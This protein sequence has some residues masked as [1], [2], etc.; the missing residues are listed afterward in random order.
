M[1]LAMMDEYAK[2]NDHFEA[3][4]VI[5]EDVNKNISD[6][7]GTYLINPS[8]SVY[9]G[10]DHERLFVLYFKAL[11]F[12]KL[13]DYESALVECRRLNEKLNILSDKYPSDNKYRRDAFINNLMG[14]IYDADGDYN[15]A[16]IAY[17]NALNIYEDD[18][19][20]LFNLSTPEQLKIDLMRSAYLSGFMDEVAFYETKFNVTYEHTPNTIGELVFFW[21]NGLGPYKDEWSINF[22]VQEG[23]GGIVTFVNEGLGL[24]FPFGM[25]DM[26]SE[27]SDITDL[28]FF[29]VAFP[30]YV[31]R[32]QTHT[33][34]T[35]SA[36][37]FT[38]E[39][40]LAED[41]NAIA[42]KVLRQRMIKEMGQSLLR[43]AIKKGLEKTAEKEDDGLGLI[44]GVF[45]AATERAD[46]RNWQ[47]LP[48]SIHYGRLPLQA[49]LNEITLNLK[50]EQGVETEKLSIQI[51]RVKTV[52]YTHQTLF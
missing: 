3:A 47:T 41:I 19:K 51:Q 12:L 38:E 21:H 31:E 5:N 28:K 11:N 22:A 34:G 37:G 43:S 33:S 4:F 7:L 8:I 52:F 6:I 9:T 15:N 45:N 49:G 23:E 35:I 17:R 44:V 27:D 29:R 26:D 50:N 25:D 42:F 48:Y 1:L 2:S 30:K 32:G 36:N 46:T 20:D 16:F 10:E 14:I 39:L 13:S 18:F 24:S 40:A